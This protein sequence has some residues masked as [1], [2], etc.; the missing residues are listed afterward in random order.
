MNNLN[1]VCDNVYVV[2]NIDAEEKLLLVGLKFKIQ[3][4]LKLLK[5]L[6]EIR[7]EKSYFFLISVQN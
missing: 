4:D 5:K 6:L 7:N 3:S 2:K 1:F